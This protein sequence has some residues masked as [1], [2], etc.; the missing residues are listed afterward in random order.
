VQ[1]LFVLT[2]GTRLH[3]Q[4]HS[5]TGEAVLF[6]HFGTGHLGVWNRVIPF[7]QPNYRVITLSLRGHG[8]S[9]KPSDG[10]TR[11]NLALDV[12]G[13]MDHLGVARAHLVG[14]SMGAEVAASLAAQWPG[15]VDSLGLEGAFQ[16]PFGR[17]GE[18]DVADS[19]IE[20]TKAQMRA[21]R[22]G[23]PQILADSEDEAVRQVLARWGRTPEGSPAF[24]EAF[25]G[26]VGRTES[27]QFALLVPAYVNDAYMESYWDARFDLDY[28][29]ITCPVLFLPDAHSYQQ[30]STRASLDWFSGLLERS[31]VVAIPE[32]A[33]A[34]V[35]I[36]QPEPF[37]AALLAFHRRTVA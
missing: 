14:S 23:R 8:R 29:R 11:E 31:E 9:E 20:A 18:I 25:R 37:A 32:A 3:V 10:Y 22:A 5:G 28:E 24:A 15:R 21:A 4:D 17:H 19:E 16:N 35:V 6:L 30:E 7:F 36:D 26:G 34:A 1:D 13:V 27:G 2:N 12:L 33:H